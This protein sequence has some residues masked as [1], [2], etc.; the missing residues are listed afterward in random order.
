MTLII[1]PDLLPQ[2][3]FY[4]LLADIFCLLDDSCTVI[5]P[6]L[7]PNNNTTEDASVC[8]PDEKASLC[9]QMGG[10]NIADI[11]C[12]NNG[13]N[14]SVLGPFCFVDYSA[15]YDNGTGFVYPTCDNGTDVSN[16]FVGITLLGRWCLLHPWRWWQCL[17]WTFVYRCVRNFWRKESWGL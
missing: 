4:R 14:Y 9:L 8:Y 12:S 17:D 7:K 13:T 5:G 16:E 15:T 2:Q 11:F 3:P 1:V 10:S 6:I